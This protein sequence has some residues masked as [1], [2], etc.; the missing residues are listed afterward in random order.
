MGTGE[1]EQELRK[2]LDMTRLISLWVLLLHFYYQ[3]YGFFRYLRLTTGVTDQLLGNIA[4]TVG[5]KKDF[6]DLHELLDNYTVAEM[7]SLH[8]KRYPYDHDRELIYANFRDFALADDDF[9]PISLKGYYWELIKE[10]IQQV[11]E[12]R[13]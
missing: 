2:I 8:P 6:W 7:I 4:V 13:G 5:R 9:D 1:N 11:L 3:C 10:D 12:N